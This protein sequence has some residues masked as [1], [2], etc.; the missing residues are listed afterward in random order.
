MLPHHIRKR[1][2]ET[3]F[4]LA[5]MLIS[6]CASPDTLI[7][8]SHVLSSRRELPAR[9]S[10]VT[11][12]VRAAAAGEAL[13]ARCS[14][15]SA[16]GAQRRGSAAAILLLLNPSVALILNA[17][18]TLY[19]CPQGIRSCAFSWV[20]LP[21]GLNALQ[22]SFLLIFVMTTSS[23]SMSVPEGRNSPALQTV[24]QQQIMDKERE[25]ACSSACAGPLP[26]CFYSM[27]MQN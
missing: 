26:C 27:A 14:Q 2:R 12:L 4:L 21:D 3:R 17:A 9:L 25:C 10:M 8:S 24:I 18:Q 22:A 1:K 6:F 15:D 7:A 16:K 5:F 23:H 11:A 20:E 13:Q 19:I